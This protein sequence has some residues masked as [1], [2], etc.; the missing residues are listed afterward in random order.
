MVGGGGGCLGG[1]GGGGGVWTG[2]ILPTGRFGRLERSFPLRPVPF[3]LPPSTFPSPPSLPARYMGP[4]VYYEFI[5]TPLLV[6]PGPGRPGKCLRRHGPTKSGL[7][8]PQGVFRMTLTFL[9]LERK[10][11]FSIF[12]SFFETRT[13][14]RTG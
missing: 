6:D 9:E 5:I 3:P 4:W 14:T 11:T 12:P 13:R 8:G 2:V 10:I 1:G 7:E